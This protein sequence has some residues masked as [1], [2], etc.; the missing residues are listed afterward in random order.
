MISDIVK[1]GAVKTLVEKV[2]KAVDEFPGC[3]AKEK[4]ELQQEIG[5]A[6]IN[7]EPRVG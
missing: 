4:D 6:L 3:S 1:R 5:E 2:T 7:A